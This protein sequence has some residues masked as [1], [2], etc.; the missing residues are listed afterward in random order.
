MSVARR[1]AGRSVL[2]VVAL[3]LVAAAWELYKSLGPEAGGDVLG[4][5]DPAEDGRNAM[6][7][8]WDMV[9]RLFDPESRASSRPIWRVVLAGVWYSFRLALSA[10]PSAPPSASALAVLMARFSVVRRG[11]LP[12]LV[13]S[14]TVPL[15]AL[16]P[17]VVSWSGRLQPFGWEWPQWL[18][19]ALLGAFLAF[20]PVSVGTLRGLEST[21]ATSLELMRSYA[22]SWRRRCA[23]S[24]SRRRSRTWSRRSGSPR[25]RPWSA[26]SWPRSPP[27]SA[28]GSAGSSSS[29]GARR[30][31]DPEKVY[32]AVFGAAVLGLLMAGCSIARHRLGSSCVDA[33]PV[34]EHAVRR[35]RRGRGASPRRST[36][37][38]HGRSMRSSTST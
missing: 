28:A 10:S 25:R 17:L 9:G 30:R 21:P 16:A 32:T 19:V 18:S 26:S 11:L 37:G 4:W 1:A 27:V 12:Y 15:I 36:P 29:T 7:H 33:A 8:V 6:P 24:A 22:A 14:Q 3:V 13:V 31:R 38:R 20:F 34:E 5:N 2:F 23:G 35:G